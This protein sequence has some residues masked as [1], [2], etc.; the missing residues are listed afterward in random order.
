[1]FQKPSP[2]YGDTIEGFSSHI[3]HFLKRDSHLKGDCL[4]G[5]GIPLR[6]GKRDL[7]NAQSEAG[8]VPFCHQKFVRSKV[9]PKAHP[10]DMGGGIG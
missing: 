4:F 3:L 2:G 10:P 5:F 8:E 9:I 7:P 1:M 6:V